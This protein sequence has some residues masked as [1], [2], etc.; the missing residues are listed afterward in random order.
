MIGHSSDVALRTFGAFCKQTGVDA[1][2]VKVVESGGGMLGMVDS[3]LG[4][5]N[6][7]GVFGYVSTLDAAIA[8]GNRDPEKTVRH[9]KFAE[10]VPDLYG[11]ALMVSRRML[12]DEPAAVAGVVRAFN[13]GLKG[14][15]AD[16]DQGIEAVMRRTSWSNRQ[17]ERLRLQRTLDIE[18]AAAEGKRLGIGDVDDARFA[19]SIA[20]LAQ[21]NRLARVPAASEV[22]TREFLPPLPERV[23]TL[24]R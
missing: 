17:V 10:H 21:T 11:S 20:L 16:I 1:A 2:R 3:M 9:L 6:V 23:T 8:A 14:V 24:A 7:H 12:R 22:F 13:A 18:M 15:V 4:S 19:R 5:R